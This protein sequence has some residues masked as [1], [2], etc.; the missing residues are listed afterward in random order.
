MIDPA[1]AALRTAETTRGTASVDPCT[2]CETI[3]SYGH[4][5]H[6]VQQ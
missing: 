5:V 6:D 4:K 2:K 1:N 3:D